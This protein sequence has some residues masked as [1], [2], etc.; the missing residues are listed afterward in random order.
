MKP[1]LLAILLLIPLVVK[2][3]TTDVLKNLQRLVLGPTPRQEKS[4]KASS[5]LTKLRDEY[6]TATREYKESLRNLLPWYEKDVKRA[7]DKLEQS[8]RMLSEGLIDHTQV[9]DYERQLVV[10]KDKVRETK[11]AIATADDQIADVLHDAALQ[12]EYRQAVQ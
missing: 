3:Q 12:Q 2:G 7:E 5:E 4:V 1:L 6:V 8:R 11:V 10:A 9:E